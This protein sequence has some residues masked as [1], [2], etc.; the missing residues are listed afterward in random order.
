[1]AYLGH[2]TWIKR[3]QWSNCD[4]SERVDSSSPLQQRRYYDHPLHIMSLSGVA[5]VVV[6]VHHLMSG[7]LE[8][9]AEGRA[10]ASI[11]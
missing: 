8:L 2:Y 10:Y 5:A 4:D 3:T 9:V 6:S 11:S 1:M 7:M